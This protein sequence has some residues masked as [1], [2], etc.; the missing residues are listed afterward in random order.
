MKI[1]KIYFLFIDYLNFN[2]IYFIISLLYPN[3]PKNSIIIPKIINVLLSNGDPVFTNSSY[4][5]FHQL[6]I[7]TSKQLN[8][9]LIKI[10]L[11][12]ISS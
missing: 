5:V 2:K 8:Y 10:C 11:N 4:L 9:I 12:F 3:T 6:Q 7:K 1:K